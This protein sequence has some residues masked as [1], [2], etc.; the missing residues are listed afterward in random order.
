MPR[1]KDIDEDFNIMDSWEELKI[2]IESVDR[3]LK[4][5]VRKGIKRSAVNSRKGLRYAKEL[6]DNIIAASYLAEEKALE[7]KAK[8]GNKDGP[9]VKAMLKKRKAS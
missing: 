7:T 5:T 6:I 9:G 2:L 8:H 4:K 1:R 3:D